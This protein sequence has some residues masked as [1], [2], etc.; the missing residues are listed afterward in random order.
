V[1]NASISCLKLGP[2]SNAAVDQRILLHH[3]RHSS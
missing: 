1:I 2:S 3:A